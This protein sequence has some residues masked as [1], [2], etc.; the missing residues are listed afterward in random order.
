MS[1]VIVNLRVVTALIEDPFFFARVGLTHELPVI[2]ANHVFLR[3]I[4]PVAQIIRALRNFARPVNIVHQKCLAVGPQSLENLGVETS[5][6]LRRIGPLL[7]LVLQIVIEEI[8][9]FNQL[10]SVP[11]RNVTTLQNSNH[12]RF[13]F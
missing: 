1:I 6:P 9:A 4:V 5:V 10:S 11:L 12:P 8:F 3:I 2:F 13:R 7:V